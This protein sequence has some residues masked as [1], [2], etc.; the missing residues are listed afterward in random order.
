MKTKAPNDASTKK[1]KSTRYSRLSSMKLK[2]MCEQLTRTC[3]NSRKRLESAQSRLTLV[4][5]ELQSREQAAE[6]VTET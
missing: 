5:E 2:S 3:D 1:R 4:S 6:K